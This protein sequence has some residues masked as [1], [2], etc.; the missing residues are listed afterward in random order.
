MMK[1]PNK[2]LNIKFS[3]LI[4]VQYF[5]TLCI[6]GNIIFNYNLLVNKERLQYICFTHCCLSERVVLLLEH[7]QSLNIY[8]LTA[9]SLSYSYHELKLVSIN[10]VISIRL[11]LL[12]LKR[13]Q[14][15]E[16]DSI[17]GS[18]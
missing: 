4:Y 14:Q 18:K 7:S 9:H 15:N 10:D 3:Y 13:L 11:S 2:T 17:L 6:Y 12:K 1:G 8:L 5:L 16:K